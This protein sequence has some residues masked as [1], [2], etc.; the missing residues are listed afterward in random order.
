MSCYTSSLLLADSEKEVKA[1]ESPQVRF[2]GSSPAVV[3]S[4]YRCACAA[5]APPAPPAPR[6]TVAM[7][8]EL[9]LCIVVV[10]VV[11]GGA[12]GDEIEMEVRS[13]RVLKMLREMV[14]QT[15][16]DSLNLPANATSIRENITDT[17]S[18]ENRTYGY[19]ADVDNECQVFHVC[20]P[21]QTPTGRNVTYRY[22]FICPAETVF[23]QE[24]LVCTR[25]RDSIPC[26]ESPSYY[27]LNMEIGK[28]N[29]EDQKVPKD[30]EIVP[31]KNQ[32][33]QPIRRKQNIIQELMKDALEQMEEIEEIPEENNENIVASEN[34][35]GANNFYIPYATIAVPPPVPVPESFKEVDDGNT[36]L[37]T[38]RYL[39][40]GRTLFRGSKRYRPEE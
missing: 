9:L 23:N 18:C 4:D 40:S 34:I 14:N 12:L 10:V 17:F 13:G 5:F 27:D 30:T 20:L 8:R 3:G 31:V 24:V 39:R 38:E 1:S 28:V 32:K 36:R 6:R 37:G 11:V 26:E 35:V 21:T 33:R 15:A 25:T 19:Y 2:P 22:S 29:K 7:A 16:A